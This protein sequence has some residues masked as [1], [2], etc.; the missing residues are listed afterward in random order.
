MGHSLT[1]Y[2]D[3]QIKYL[4]TVS[5]YNVTLFVSE[6]YRKESAYIDVSQDLIEKPKEPKIEKIR[7]EVSAKLSNDSVSSSAST[8]SS[9]SSIV[10][11]DP[12]EQISTSPDVHNDPARRI[13]L[14]S[15]SSSS[16]SE[17]ES[18]KMSENV[19]D[20]FRIRRRRRRRNRRR[21]IIGT[22]FGGNRFRDFIGHVFG[23]LSNFRFLGPFRSKLVMV[24]LTQT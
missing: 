6:H 22:G 5:H 14:D 18:E 23:R 2:K 15:T 13:R 1:A 12:V 8:I 4:I 19:S 11:T 16:S 24:A 10:R 7:E 20:N 9:A 21:K 17:S 3:R